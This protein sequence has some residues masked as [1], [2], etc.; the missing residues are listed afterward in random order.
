MHEEIIERLRASLDA[1]TSTGAIAG[2]LLEPDVELIQA[3][4]IIDTAGEFRGREGLLEA[5]GEL[6]E[7]FDD[8]RFELEEAIP[9]SEGRIVALM[10]VHGRG[11]GSG[12]QLDNRIAWLITLREERVSRIVVYEEREEALEAAGL[13]RPAG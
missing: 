12:M 6:R 3:S 8:L 4:S 2:D 7:A 10:R 5:L 9:A 11:R 13:P 1:F